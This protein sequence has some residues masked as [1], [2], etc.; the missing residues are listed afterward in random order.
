MTAGVIEPVGVGVGGVVVVVGVCEGVGV[1]KVPVIV[2]VNVGVTVLV[3]TG[4]GVCVG[5]TL[6]PS[7]LNRAMVV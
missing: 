4:E 1:C 5:G 3:G 7:N 6:A 2:A